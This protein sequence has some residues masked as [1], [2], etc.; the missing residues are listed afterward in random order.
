MEKNWIKE[1]L[2]RLKWFLTP[3]YGREELLRKEN[4][5]EGAGTTPSLTA[6]SRKAS[7]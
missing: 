5:A 7:S 6:G 1:G 4:R 3:E 2:F